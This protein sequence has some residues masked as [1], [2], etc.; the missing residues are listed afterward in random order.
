MRSTFD[1]AQ[2]V[3]NH[4]YKM[5]RLLIILF[6]ISIYTHSFAE[7]KK[8]DKPI[9]E[10]LKKYRISDD[11]LAYSLIDLETGE[12]ISN[13]Q[14]KRMMIPAST[15]KLITVFY[16]LSA[17]GPEYK[18]Q[19]S[20]GYKGSIKNGVLKGDIY[21]R[22]GGDPYLTTQHLISFVHAS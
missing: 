13:Y 15:M 18:F 14:Q 21:L 5:T 2:S 22:G 20:I 8:L 4:R 7:E 12:F 10:I 17:L 11:S 16:A 1:K 9:L 6:L 19:T 3:L